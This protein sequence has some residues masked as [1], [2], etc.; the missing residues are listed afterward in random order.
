[1]PNGAQE[2]WFDTTQRVIEGVMD[3][4]HAWA[5]HMPGCEWDPV[6]AQ[7]RAQEMFERMFTM[8]WLPPGRGL[9][10]M[11]SSLT[12]DRP[13]YAALNNCGFVSTAEAGKFTCPSP[14]SAW[15]FADP[16][17]SAPGADPARPFAFLMD[18]A[19]LGVGVG[20]D[21]VG[22]GGKPWRGLDASA[23][24]AHY[25]VP[26]TREGWVISVAALL[27]AHA[28]GGPGI[29]FDYSG[30]RP[31]GS[32]VRGFGGTAAGPD[33]LRELH[34]D[35]CSLL[36][37]VQ[38]R[39]LNSR[40]IVDIMNI[41]GKAVVSGASRR[42]AEIAFGQ[43]DDDMF[44][45]LKDYTANPQRAAWGWSSNNSVFATVGMDYSKI[46]PL[47]RTNGEPG[48][49][50]LDTM[51]A[52]GRLADPPTHADH[53][54]A[55]ANPCNEQSLESFELCCL[56][57]TFPARHDDLADFCRTL[58][59]ATHYAKVVTLG[60]SHW[61]STREVM[62]RNRR[63]GCS[64]SG[65]AQFLA[66]HGEAELTRWCDTGYAAVQ[67]ADAQSSAAL[68]VPRSI[69]CT[70]IKPSGTVSLLAGATPGMHYP[71]AAQYI[72]R[73]RV[74]DDSPLLAPLQAAGY[75]VE[76]SV[77]E[78]HTAVVS[79]P[80]HVGAGVP[81]VSQVSMEDQLALAALLQKHWADNQ[82]SC[83]V[84][85]DPD[86]EGGRLAGALS[87]FDRQLKGVSF[88]PR[89]PAG[90]YPQM[91]YEAISLE[92]YTA[93]ADAIAPQQLTDALEQHV[94]ADPSA[95]AWCDADSCEAPARP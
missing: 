26:D 94:Q 50:W 20:F 78:P 11:G 91:P 6:R 75:T 77:T 88:L 5:G 72:R 57:E 37:D 60:P 66:A 3:L 83:T 4:E 23:A 80:V 44:L 62:S 52:Y 67:Q 49:A 76:P 17:L 43:P 47:I 39:A 24:R 45:S 46:A 90:A 31:R 89:L 71:E 56:V 28:C 84:S 10:A 15:L 18:H 54:V 34:H 48:L 14:T 53:K 95:P 51:R 65:I 12:R 87:T 74:A 21:T 85:F 92:E 81:A 63:M 36:R 19:L 1:M 29:E 40:D 16:K 69:K 93:A 61:A 33:V 35:I 64:M 73:V 58:E 32:P 79:F 7:D 9:W 13:L 70:S 8:K 82:V 38:G 41:V 68:H 2:N 25:T 59:L 27:R 22:A 30:I 42:T 86:A 55:G